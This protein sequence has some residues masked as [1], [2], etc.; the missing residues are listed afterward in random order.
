MCGMRSGM[1]GMNGMNSSN[2]EV[3]DVQRSENLE[4]CSAGVYGDPVGLGVMGDARRFAGIVFSDGA[5]GYAVHCDRTHQLVEICVKAPERDVH[6]AP[7]RTEQD[8]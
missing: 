1:H 8:S 6:R 5:V 7:D 3:D 2:A 4:I